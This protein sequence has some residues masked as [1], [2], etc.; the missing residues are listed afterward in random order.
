MFIGYVL[1][2]I[3]AHLQGGAKILEQQEERHSFLLEGVIQQIWQDGL[4][5]N[6]PVSHN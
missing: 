2:R 5:I 1:Y 3:L 6:L 4:E